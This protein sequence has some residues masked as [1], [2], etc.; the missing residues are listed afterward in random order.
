MLRAV[1]FFPHSNSRDLSCSTYLKA[2]CW[3]GVNWPGVSLTL[4]INQSL[5]LTHFNSGVTQEVWRLF[6]FCIN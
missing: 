3:F 2:L 4:V 5:V 1:C 6:S